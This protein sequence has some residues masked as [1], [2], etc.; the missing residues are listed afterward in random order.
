MKP[1]PFC[2]EEIQDA[3]IKCRFCGSMLSAQEPAPAIVP[4]VPGAAAGAIAPA[5]AGR[6]VPP[7]EAQVLYEGHPSW[8]AWFFRTIAAV[9]VVVAAIVG[10]IAILVMIESA[11]GN[12]SWYLIG[13]AVV[14]VFGVGWYVWLLLERRSTRVRISTN[15]I[16]LET[17]IFGR[18]IDTVQLWRV[19]DIDFE[20]TFAE[21]LLGIARIRILSH[22]KLQP[23]ILLRGMPGSRALFDQLRDGIAIARQARNVVGVVD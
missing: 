23:E 3:A 13:A 19:R 15:S 16:D 14:A 17:G 6:I 4:Q 21:R 1:C 10:M 20:Q 2:A 8:K 12:R 5:A 9:L 18:T 22:D 11:D 7:S